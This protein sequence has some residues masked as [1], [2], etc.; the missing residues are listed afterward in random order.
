MVSG[1]DKGKKKLKMTIVWR[2]SFYTIFT[3]SQRPRVVDLKEFNNNFE[4]P[5]I[6]SHFVICKANYSQSAI[7]HHH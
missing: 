6:E 3:S 1:T 7:P 4:H 2:T 5:I